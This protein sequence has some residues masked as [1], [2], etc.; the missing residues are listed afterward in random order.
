MSVLGAI[1]HI[2]PIT[3]ALAAAPLSL[4]PVSASS[5][6]SLSSSTTPSSATSSSSQQSLEIHIPIPPTTGESR[7]AALNLVS[8]KG[9]TAL[10]ALREAR[11]VQK[12]R[13]RQLELSGK[14]GL[15]KAKKAVRELEG[16]N[17][18]GV[19]RVKM[20]VEEKRRVLGEG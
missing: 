19:G 3:M 18:G 17:Q 4:T 8:G 7:Q 1:Q 15:E 9:E 5:S 16:V 14:I 2:K 6:S 13:I 11:G 12:K 10:F 20:I